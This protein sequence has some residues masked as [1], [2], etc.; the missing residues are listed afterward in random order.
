MHRRC[1]LALL[2]TLAL[3][4]CSDRSDDQGRPPPPGEVPT[5]AARANGAAG[6]TVEPAVPAEPTA[7]ERATVVRV[8]DGDTIDVRLEDGGV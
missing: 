3:A 5:P 8:I 1:G 4:A 7:L 6:L 2:V